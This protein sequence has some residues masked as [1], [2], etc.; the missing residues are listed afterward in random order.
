M[1]YHYP[2]YPSVTKYTDIRHFISDIPTRFGDKIALSYRPMPHDK[3]AVRVTYAA[4]AEDVRALG[5]ELLARGMYG[6]HLALI[7]GLS[8]EWVCVYFAAL[9]CG[10]VLVPL[11]KEWT[12]EDLSA[13]VSTAECSLLV[14]D[15]NIVSKADLICKNNNL[16]TPIYLTHKTEEAIATLIASGKERIAAGDT[17][18]DTV[19]IDPTKLATLVFTSGTTGQGKGVMLNQQALLANDYYGL[20]L[21]TAKGKTLAVLPPH[22]TFGSTVGLFMILTLGAELYISSGLKYVPR[23]LQN[24]KPDFLVIVPLFLETFHRRVWASVKEKGKEKLVRR[25][26]KVSNALRKVGI[27]L[28][29]KFFGQILS[30]FGGNVTM[31]VCGGAPLNPEVANDFDAFGVAVQ[32][33]YGI[34]ECAPLIAVNRNKG[35]DPTCVGMVIPCDEIKFIDVGEDGEGEICVK[36]PNVM[37]GYWKNEEAT[38]EAIDEDGFFHTGDFGKQDRYGRLFITGRK[39]NLII[40][41][42]GKNVYPEEIETAIAVT[43]PG[44]TDIVVYEGESARG[45][46]YNTVVAE[47]HPD[48]DWCK[49]QNIPEDLIEAYFHDHVENYNRT[50]VPYKKI[51][52]VRIRQEAF[53]KNTLRKIVRFKIN[54]QI[55]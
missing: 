19:E 31:A 32:N 55:P 47:I 24:E 41:S 11:D 6:K 22:H 37:M 28:R 51:G 54:K 25:M 50:A 21:I 38:R 9:S 16:P 18:F 12:A 44:I 20:Q 45:I 40:L 26:M 52:M 23:E 29:K 15:S 46:S 5:T 36:G 8:Y 4:F 33:G 2:L 42:N 1:K 34:T 17:S 53:P 7:G 14:C 27:D 39:K 10:I 49:A 30:A 13:T 3:E 43:T 35:Y 48:F